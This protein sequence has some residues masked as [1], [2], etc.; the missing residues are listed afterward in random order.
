MCHFQGFV[1]K[2]IERRQLKFGEKPKMNVVK[3]TEG[4]AQE[5]GL[6]VVYPQADEY[7]VE[8]LYKYR[9]RDSKAK[10]CPRCNV[11]YD[12]KAADKYED[13]RKKNVAE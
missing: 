7:L 9:V 6:Q 2:V 3:A 5:D 8:F 4:G 11:V 10:L 1:A 12:E 13:R